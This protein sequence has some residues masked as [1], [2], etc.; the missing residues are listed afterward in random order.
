ML[1][2]PMSLFYVLYCNCRCARKIILLDERYY[3]YIPH[4][5]SSPDLVNKEG[6]AAMAAVATFDELLS[7]IPPANRGQLDSK[8]DAD[9][10]LEEI[11][12]VLICW[13][14]VR[15]YLG[16]SVA[17]EEAIKRDSL[18]VERER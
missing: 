11:G 14:G 3:T 15:P 4:T 1:N 18:G 2:L 5:H 10:H 16:L 6:G 12:K 8:I 17:E 9:I 13:E 7:R